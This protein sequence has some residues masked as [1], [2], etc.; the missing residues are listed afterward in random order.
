MWKQIKLLASTGLPDVVDCSGV[1]YHG[2]SRA[3]KELMRIPR[4]KRATKTSLKRA[5]EFAKDYR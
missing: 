5:F 2:A 1:M 3:T 4:G